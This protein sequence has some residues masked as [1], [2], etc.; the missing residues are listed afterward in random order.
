MLDLLSAMDNLSAFSLSYTASTFSVFNKTG[1]GK[2]KSVSQSQ[3]D[4]F[5]INAQ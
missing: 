4:N 1:M 3:G 2:I 5:T